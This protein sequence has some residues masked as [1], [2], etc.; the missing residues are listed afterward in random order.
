[1]ATSPRFL[2]AFSVITFEFITECLFDM[3]LLCDRYKSDAFPAKVT[4]SLG[5]AMR[6]EGDP[7]VS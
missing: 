6:S 1:V 5:N 3:W 4:A 7:C 2:G